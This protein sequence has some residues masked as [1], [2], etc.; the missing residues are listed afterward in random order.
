VGIGSEI[1]SKVAQQTR[2]D[3]AGIADDMSIAETINQM[4]IGD[5]LVE[6]MF[7]KINNVYPYIF[8]AND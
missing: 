8:C 3:A 1:V 6:I 7:R 2:T 4:E 5:D